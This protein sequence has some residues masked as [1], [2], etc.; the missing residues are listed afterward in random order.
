MTG[1]YVGGT[2]SDGTGVGRGG[3]YGVPTLSGGAGGG[4]IWGTNDGADWGKIG[5]A[6]AG[7]SGLAGNGPVLVS[8]IS[9]RVVRAVASLSV[10]GA[11]GEFGVGCLRACTMSWAPAMIKSTEDASGMVTFV[12]NHVNVSEIR[13]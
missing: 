7:S 4:T 11:N 2:L 10:S 6:P 12:G 3:L 1:S 9:V 8:K 5:G 13:S